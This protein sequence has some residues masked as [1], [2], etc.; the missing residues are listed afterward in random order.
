MLALL[1]CFVIFFGVIGFVIGLLGEPVVDLVKFLYRLSRRSRSR[2]SQ[3][4]CRPRA[5]ATPPKAPAKPAK[6]SISKDSTSDSCRP[7]ALAATARRKYPTGISGAKKR[8][9]APATA[10]SR[11]HLK[12]PTARD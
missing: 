4:R 11:Q 7:V 9:T 1:I 12:I 2:R 3:G 5:V 10:C 8:K 6:S